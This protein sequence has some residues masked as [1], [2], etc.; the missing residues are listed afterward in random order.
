MTAQDIITGAL[1]RI[2]SYMPGETLSAIDG[3]DALQVLNDLLDSWST[4]SAFVYGSV[5]SVLTFVPLQYQYTI[6][7]GGNFN[8]PRPLRVT[9]AFTRLSQIDYPMD[10]TL[11]QNRYTEI[12][13]KNVPSPWPI[14]CWYN[15]TYPLGNLYF[16]PNPSS[17]G[18]LHLF[19]DTILTQFTSLSQAV[20]LPQ[21]Y[22]R[23]LKW[24]LAREICS[25]YGFPL[26]PAIEKLAKEALDMVKSLNMEPTPVSSYD[27]ALM[28]TKDRANA[29]WILTGG[30]GNT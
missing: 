21:G 11:D 17:A 29:G 28:N 22:A 5:E 25:E 8:V 3:N 2:N 10:V 19:T 4:Q 24:G 23:A 1:K 13:L 18:E 27:V 16:Y 14:V 9:N 12:G 26:S 30:F 15:P 7:T 6:G 20:T